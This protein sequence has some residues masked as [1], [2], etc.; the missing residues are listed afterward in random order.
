MD[1]YHDG[2]LAQAETLLEALPPELSSQDRAV[3]EVYRGL[4]AFARDATNTAGEAFRRALESFPAIQLDDQIHS[5]SRVA[6]FDSVRSD[7]LSRWRGAAL[8]AERRGERDVA[9]DRWRAVLAAEPADPIAAEGVRRL[10]EG[11]ELR[12]DRLAGRPPD[13]ERPAEVRTA[14]PWAAVGLGLLVPGGGEFYVGQPA[15]G[16]LVLALAGGAAA[17]G[18]LFTRVEVSCRTPTAAECP[19]E[20]VLDER[21]TRPYLGP[22]LAAAAVITLIGAI[23]AG[24]SAARTPVAAVS[25]AASRT[26]VGADGSV[27]VTLFRLTH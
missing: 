26:N 15:R 5:P 19:P 9:L 12:M 11:E 23:D 4:V 13:R 6:L 21:E 22:G 25:R 10:M 27:R 2:D 1:A 14:S 18:V 7:L 3:A 24:L 20:D 8:S 17:A 16:A